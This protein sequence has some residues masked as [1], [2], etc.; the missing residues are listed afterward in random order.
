MSC[1]NC[2]EVVPFQK[3]LFRGMPCKHCNS[4][5]LVSQTYSRALVLLALLLAEALLWV[6][7]I[8]TLFY[9]TLGLPFGV[10]ASFWLGFPVAFFLLTV[11]VRTIQRWFPPTLVLRHWSTVTT[12]G[13]SHDQETGK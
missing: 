8:R 3:E 5:L 9:P 13:L 11:I 7:N 10:L 1:P 4:T 2:R 6:G 12:L